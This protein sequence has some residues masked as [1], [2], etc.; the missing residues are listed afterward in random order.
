MASVVDTSD[1]W[2]FYRGGMSDSELGY[3]GDLSEEQ[4]RAMPLAQQMQLVSQ[5]GNAPSFWRD[6]ATNDIVGVGD[7]TAFGQTS[8]WFDPNALTRNEDGSYRIAGS[9]VDF[10]RLQQ[11]QDETDRSGFFSGDEPW[12]NILRG[13]GLV[14]GGGTLANAGFLDF[15]PGMA[16]GGVDL[17]ITGGL[18][19]EEAAMGGHFT[20]GPGYMGDPYSLDPGFFDPASGEA[21]GGT[22]L[23]SGG[24]LDPET[25][26]LNGP[27]QAP[28]PGYMGDPYSLDPGFFDANGVPVAGSGVPQWLR[29]ALDLGRDL[30]GGGAPGGGNVIAA[31]MGGQGGRIGE[32]SQITD[33]YGLVA[34][35]WGPWSGLLDSPKGK[36]VDAMM[37]R[38]R[39]QGL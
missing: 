29:D 37:K 14:L 12:E 34:S 15:L 24:G 2:A 31:L 18:A 16:E 21:L 7:P 23:G 39:T 22:G 5:V 3:T 8:G 4:F 38:K 13:A 30:L 1:L 26:A 25:W 6:D 19:P 11:M 36:V 10:G 35:G 28:P 20:P 27:G 17:G 32:H 33:P 9:G